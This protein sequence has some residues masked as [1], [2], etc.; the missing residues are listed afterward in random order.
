MSGSWRWDAEDYARSSQAQLGWAR[1]LI[2]K[3]ALRGDESV[4]DIGC[5]D[6][7]VTAEIARRVPR[8]G[9][10]GID[11]SEDMVRRARETWPPARFPGLVFSL[12]DA[13]SLAFDAR[14]DVV[15]SNAT[16]HWVKDHH[17]VLRGI[18]RSLRPGGRMLLQ[19]GGRGNGDAI[20]AVAREMIDEPSWCGYFEGF[21]FPWGFYGPEEYAPWC[22]EAGLRPSRIELLPKTMTQD[23]PEGLAAWIRTTWMPFTARVPEERRESFITEAARRYIARH[24]LDPEGRAAVLMVRLE[25]EASKG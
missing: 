19:M 21:E 20:F 18:A 13:R 12:A 11:S 4:L 23:G 14:F 3:L 7:K 24:P 25:V 6:G 22:R 8:G 15:F 9:V 1:E 17:P 16:L 10:T 5:G 2:D